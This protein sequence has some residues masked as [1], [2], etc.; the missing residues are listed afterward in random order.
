MKNYNDELD[1][2]FEK[3]QKKSGITHFFQDGLMYRGKIREDKMWRFPGN[4]SEMWDIAPKRVMFLLKDV[5]ARGDGPAADDDIRARIFRDTSALIYLNMS[6]WLFGLLKTIE[7]GQIPDFTFS[8]ADATQFFDDTP[9]AYVNCKKEAGTNTINNDTLINH[10]E[11][12]N[13]NLIYEITMLDPDIIICCGGSSSI[14][15]FVEKEIYTDLEKINESNNWIYYS[16]NNNK[17][18]IDSFHPSYWQIGGEYRG[19]KKIYELM[20]PKFKEFLDEYPNF[21]KP[22]R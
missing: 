12:D 15:D 18:V 7:N 22:C 10:I 11:T 9:V 20:M 17:V 14:K 3:W 5:N 19:A 4:E 8:N 16:K 13:K 21:L 2:L 1:V 6:Y